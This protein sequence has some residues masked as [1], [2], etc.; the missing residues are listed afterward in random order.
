MTNDNTSNHT[1]IPSSSHINILS[2]ANA[3]SGSYLYGLE[4][5]IKVPIAVGDAGG[6]R[7]AN[8]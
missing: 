3:L 6:H 2:Q 1:D 4:A 8:N 5:H 7:R